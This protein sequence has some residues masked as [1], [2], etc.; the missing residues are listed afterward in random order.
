MHVLQWKSKC[1]L[2]ISKLLNVDN[3]TQT[4]FPNVCLPC[5]TY[6]AIPKFAL[7]S[8][9][10][11]L[12]I[13][14][15]RVRNLEVKQKSKCFGYTRGFSWTEQGTIFSNSFVLPQTVNSPLTEGSALLEILYSASQNRQI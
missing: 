14:M 3:S 4:V 15:P 2:Y 11:F 9:V 10:L 12:C 5:D 13:K 6:R 7:Y 8:V 1:H